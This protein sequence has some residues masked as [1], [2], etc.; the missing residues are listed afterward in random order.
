M[1]SM[2]S[3]SNWLN[4]MK[5]GDR[6]AVEQIW[7]RYFHRL[8]QLARKRLQKFQAPLVENEEDIAL[9]A[10]HSFWQAAEQGRFPQLCDREDLWQIL[11]MITRRKCC[12]LIEHE[13]RDKRDV[14]RR[15]AEVGC[16]PSEFAKF[17]AEEPTPDFAVQIA[18]EYQ[19]L[20]SLLPDHHMQRIAVDRMEGY[21]RKEIAQ[22][23]ECSEETIKR[24]LGIIRDIWGD[25]I[26][27]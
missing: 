2:G 16:E 8:V 23:L 9:S 20:L 1:T 27:D 25:E 11:V 4:L 22:R 14:R 26:T 13:T 10:F 21:T 24:R 19:R 7:E 5:E 18:E 15:L 3:V 17:I 6:L 12:D